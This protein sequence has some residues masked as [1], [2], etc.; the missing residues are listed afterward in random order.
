M[1]DESLVSYEREYYK[2]FLASYIAKVIELEFSNGRRRSFNS[3]LHCCLKN[4]KLNNIERDEVFNLVDEILLNQYELLV[5]NASK[6]EKM[7]L[8]DLKKEREI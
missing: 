1:D 7:F 6:S 5:A 3:F 8:V 2:Q 4:Y